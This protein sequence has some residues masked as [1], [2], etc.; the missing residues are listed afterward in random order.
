MITAV[1]EVWTVANVVR[2][3]FLFNSDSCCCVTQSF[4]FEHGKLLLVSRKSLRQHVSDSD[5]KV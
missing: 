3:E 5:F 2:R 4:F 1:S